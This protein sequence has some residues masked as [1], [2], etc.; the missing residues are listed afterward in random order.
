ML[1]VCDQ[2]E[3][4]PV[5]TARATRS[6]PPPLTNTAAMISRAIAPHKRAISWTRLNF[7]FL[8]FLKKR[9]IRL[10]Y[11]WSGRGRRR[12]PHSPFTQERCAP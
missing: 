11:G 9:F 8:T 3:M 1:A 5:A 4:P 6:M 2:G 12:Y 7:T 10:L